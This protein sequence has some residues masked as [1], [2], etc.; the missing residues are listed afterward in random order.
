[1]QEL[2][3]QQK[4]HSKPVEE[5][6]LQELKEQAK[7]TGVPLKIYKR[8]V[9]ASKNIKKRKIYLKDIGF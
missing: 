4:E 5:Y 6:T 9:E 2:L 7:I 1:M 8:L 3:L